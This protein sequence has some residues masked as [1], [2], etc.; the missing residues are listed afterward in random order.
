[1]ENTFPR[2][3]RYEDFPGYSDFP[4]S[5][6]AADEAARTAVA[7]EIDRQGSQAFLDAHPEYFPCDENSKLLR[8]WLFLHGELP[9]TRLNLEIAQRELGDDLQKV[10]SPESTAIDPRRG[11]IVSRSDVLAEYRPSAGEATAL[12]AVADSVDLNDHQR[13]VRDRKL[14]LLAGEQRRKLAAK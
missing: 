7:A 8:A 9:A 14:A 2:F 3:Q 13:K 1:M 11:I 10:P 5:G 12:S 4:R 6:N